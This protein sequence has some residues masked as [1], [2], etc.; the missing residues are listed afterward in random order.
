[1]SVRQ[2]KWKDSGG[3]L[4]VGWWVDVQYQYPTGRIVRVRKASPVNTRRGAEEYERQ[5]R[6]SILAGTYGKEKNQQEHQTPTVGDFVTR[7]LTYSENNNKPSTVSGKRVVLD[8]HILPVFKKY[9]LDEIGLAEIE[10]FKALMKKKTSASRPRKDSPTKWAV[11]KRYGKPGKLLNPKTINNVLATFRRMLSLAYEQGVIKSMPRVKLFRIDKGTFDFLDFEEA[12]RLVASAD[13][14]WRTLLLVALKT[15]LR[16]GELIGLQWADVDLH[17]GRL[18]VRRT[19]WRGMAGLPKSGRY[20]TVDLPE[21]VVNALRVHRRPGVIPVFSNLDG[22]ILSPGKMK[23]ALTRALRLSG[24]SRPEGRIG[25]HD[26]RHTYGSHLAMRGQP[27]KVIQELMGHATVEMTMRYAHLSPD[28]RHNAV[29][30]LDAPAP[31]T[32]TSSAILAGARPGFPSEVDART[33]HRRHIEG[34]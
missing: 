21:S 34:S 3:K 4:Q 26:L 16:M 6:H 20:R 12:E 9:R 30:A 17:R 33:A 29:Q 25:W 5:L 7:F 22:S 24:I 11:K 19:V 28:V 31:D 2:R 8:Q 10:D 15:G 18:Q 1:M 27:L 32:S 13:P 23:T 14:E